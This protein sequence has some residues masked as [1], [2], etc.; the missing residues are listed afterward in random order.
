M[1]YLKKHKE[2]HEKMESQ[3]LLGFQ[4]SSDFPTEKEQLLSV[5]QPCHDGF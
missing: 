1:R 2:A 4:S 5:P 3:K